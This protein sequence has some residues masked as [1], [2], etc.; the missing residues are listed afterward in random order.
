MSPV[1]DVETMRLSTGGEVAFRM[2]GDAGGS[3][4][5]LLHGFPNSSWMFRDVIG[6]L[7]GSVRV[8][9][10]DL[11]GFGGSDLPEEPSF[12]GMTGAIEELLARLDVGRRFFSLHDFGAP[13]ALKLAM[14]APELVDGLIIQ[15][16]NAHRAGLGPQWAETKAF[17]AAPTAENERPA[18]AHL[19]PEGTR[20]QYYSGVPEEVAARVD[21]AGWRED[22]R[23]MNLP[24]RMDFHKALVA[25]YGRYVE[26][27][28]AIG[29]YLAERQPP[30]LL[31][32]GRHDIYFDIAEVHSWLVELPRMEAH[33]LDG[34]H[35]LVETHA[36]RVAELMLAFVQDRAA[37]RGA[38]GFAHGR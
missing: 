22:W 29:E 3:T 25:D 1:S 4:L 9:A 35:L 12:D 13:V 5:V 7:S 6:P 10:A 37:G 16:A 11:P 38:A 17:W 8:V 14:Q 28:G 23:V 30:A 18:M 31:I 34:G 36:E 24:G 26:R 15:N 32:W 19:T 33:V 27:F 2:A 20:D 21:P